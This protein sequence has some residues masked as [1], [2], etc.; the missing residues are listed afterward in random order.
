VFSGA[1]IGV[2]PFTRTISIVAEADVVE[3]ASKELQAILDD[4]KRVLRHHDRALTS[5]AL[6]TVRFAVGSGLNV[7]ELYEPVHFERIRVIDYPMKPSVENIMITFG[8]FG[9]PVEVAVHSVNKEHQTKELYVIF[10]R[11]GEALNSVKGLSQTF[12]CT[13]HGIPMCSLCSRFVVSQSTMLL[14]QKLT[15]IHIGYYRQTM[16]IS[17]SSRF[18][19]P[20]MQVHV[21]LDIARLQRIN[22]FCCATI[23]LGRA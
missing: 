5:T 9:N 20:F 3:A 18:S 10:E 13:A 14:R 17:S 6:G 21:E 11:H 1:E 22:L 8:S 23:E 15:I 2:D 4:R 16:A 7:T 19:A 12:L